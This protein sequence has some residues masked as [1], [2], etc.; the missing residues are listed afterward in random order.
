[1]AGEWALGKNKKG[2][3]FCKR[4]PFMAGKSLVLLI[5][6]CNLIFY[7]AVVVKGIHIPFFLDTTVGIFV[8]FM[9]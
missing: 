3:L 4:E 5:V 6:Q 8:F 7:L 2:S 9:D 1:M